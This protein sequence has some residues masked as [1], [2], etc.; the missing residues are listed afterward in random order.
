MGRNKVKFE[1]NTYDLYADFDV[2]KLLVEENP[3]IDEFDF[4]NGVV[5]ETNR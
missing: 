2:K 1:F 3:N 5:L 4:S